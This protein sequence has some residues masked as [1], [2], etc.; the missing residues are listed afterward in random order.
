L[1]GRLSGIF[2]LMS[3]PERPTST[4]FALIPGKTPPD[5]T[6]VRARLDPEQ[7][8][9]AGAEREDFERVH[10]S[11]RDPEGALWTF[12]LEV[13][14]AVV[15]VAAE[16]VPPL[17][18]WHF[19]QPRW[20]ADARTVAEKA[21]WSISV[22]THLEDP[23]LKALGEQLALALA[24]SGTDCPALFDEPSLRLWP[25]GEVERLLKG[26]AGC[27]V[28]ELCSIHSVEPG[29][30]RVWLHTH[31]LARAGAPD[32]DALLV[33]EDAQD[34]AGELLNA[35]AS[36][37]L[38]HGT[39]PVGT[40]FPVGEGIEIAL[41]RL[42]DALSRVPPDVPGGKDSRDPS[43]R[44]STRRVVAPA[45]ARRGGS[46]SLESLV[47]SARRGP[48]FRSLEA[49]ERMAILARERWG[50]FTSL[51]REHH[52]TPGFVF[53]VKLGYEPDRARERQEELAREHLW[54]RVRSID[55]GK[56]EA[57]LESSPLDIA[58]LKRGDLR[59]HELER[60][61]E[62]LVVTPAGR[63]RPDSPG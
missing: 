50:E 22:E 40:P 31:G 61:T 10:G 5:E 28:H 37:L 41:L 20:P 42:E 53:L 27:G 35:T 45:N 60:L 47:P 16:P 26:K 9:L 43:H 62:W 1:V 58:A 38:S 59:S 19:E 29:A 30:S 4:V 11:R 39:P 17:H 51:F 7:F 56:I 15:R 2:A 21:R 32:L 48:F 13:G 23:P 33:P 18:P 46:P 25:A 12:Y 6:L 52:A 34:V 63:L 8:D 3:R 54:F 14:G 57:M 36:L 55:G 49:T 44:E 24:L